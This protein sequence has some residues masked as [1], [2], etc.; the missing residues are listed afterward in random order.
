M[1]ASETNPAAPAQTVD[2]AT[3]YRNHLAKVASAADDAATGLRTLFLYLRTRNPEL[4]YI[5]VEYDG[6]GD[7]GQIE[8]I[9]YGGNKPSDYVAPFSVDVS[10]DQ[11]LPEEVAQ[12]RTHQPGQWQPGVGWVATG[13]RVGVTAN[14]L[15]DELAWDLA[16]GRNPGFEINEGGYGRIVIAADE[17]DPARVRISLSHSERIIETNDYEYEL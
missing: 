13:E 3:H 10:E 16:Y 15:I 5:E 1:T 8:S 4:Q 6:G 11:P 12:E 9:F 2:F 14:Q 7:S 17:E